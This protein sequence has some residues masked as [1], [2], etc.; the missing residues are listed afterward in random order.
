VSP[1]LALKSICE[2]LGVQST[3]TIVSA[4]IHELPGQRKHPIWLHTMMHLPLILWLQF[5]YLLS[6]ALTLPLVVLMQNKSTVAVC[7]T[8]LW[9]VYRH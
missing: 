1:S 7:G 3:Y 6:S 9:V 8:E 4:S 5:P 2:C